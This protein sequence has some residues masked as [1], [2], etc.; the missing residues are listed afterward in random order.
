[1]GFL[2]GTNWDFLSQKTAF[3]IVAAVKTSNLT[4]LNFVLIY[5]RVYY[6]AVKTITKLHRQNVLNNISRKNNNPIFYSY[7]A[8]TVP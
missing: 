3:F 8:R 7:T 1:M 2:W 6:A 4:Q 5:L